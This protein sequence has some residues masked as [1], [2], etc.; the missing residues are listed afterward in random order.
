MVNSGRSDPIKVA[1]ACDETT[2]VTPIAL[3]TLHGFGHEERSQSGA[4]RRRYRAILRANVDDNAVRIEDLV[5]E[6][7]PLFGR[8]LDHCA[9]SRRTCSIIASGFGSRNPCDA[10]R[11]TPCRRY[12]R[13][14]A[15]SCSCS[16]GS[17]G[18]RSPSLQKNEHAL[19][20]V[21]YVDD[22]QPEHL[23]IELRC[24]SR[25]FEAKGQCVSVSH[26]G[27]SLGAVVL[28]P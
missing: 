16:R 2:S 10:N 26:G 9:F 3:V 18:S 14:R 7:R 19:R 8:A 17:P 15:A 13:C 27:P 11:R 21:P 20:R 6:V 12:G 23:V 28:M 22:F 5:L 1:I 4:S 24:S 25:S